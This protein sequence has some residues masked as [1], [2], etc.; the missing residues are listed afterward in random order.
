MLDSLKPF[1]EY[2]VKRRRESEGLLSEREALD[3]VRERLKNKN[4]LPI[5]VDLYHTPSSA[6]EAKDLHSKI[7]SLA[8]ET[9]A[10][11]ETEVRTE[12]IVFAGTGV[13]PFFIREGTIS[14]LYAGGVGVKR[15]DGGPK[16]LVT[17]VVEPND[18]EQHIKWR[19]TVPKNLPLT[20]RIEYDE[21]STA[22]AR[23]TADKISAI[24]KDLGVSEVVDIERTLVD[25]VPETAILG[26]WQAITKG[27]IRRIFIKPTGVCEFITMGGANVPGKWFLTP[28]EIFMDIKNIDK[29][30]Y[31]V[32]HGHLDKEGNLVVYRGEIVLQGS[33]GSEPKSRIVFKKVY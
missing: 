24:A 18:V 3:Y 4:N 2:W 9:N 33:I 6:A 23:Q 28:K 8:K 22:L 32:H 19:L 26:S 27:D 15:P 30:A 12:L 31:F 7:V 20:F 29:G 5:R 16:P 1:R 21:T 25:S 10:Q 11:M 14:T 13:S 17:G